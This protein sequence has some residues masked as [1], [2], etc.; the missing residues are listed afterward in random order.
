MDQ[1]RWL[2]KL[3]GYDYEIE[4]KPGRE[5]VAVDT[6]SRVHGELTAITYP[7][8]TWLAIV[9]HKAHNDPLLIAMRD[10]LQKGTKSIS[11]YKARGG[12][13]WYKGKLVL[14][15]NSLHMEAIIREFH[16]TPLGNTP[17]F[18]EL[19][20]VWLPTSIGWA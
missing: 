16:D 20:N 14:S 1:Q 8:P 13:L 3:M 15:P 18:S 11:G 10:D 7:R 5:N 6:L 19:L 17:E 4:Y 12:Q 2:V 9:C